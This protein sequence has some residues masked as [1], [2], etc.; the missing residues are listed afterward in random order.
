MKLLFCTKFP[1]NRRSRSRRRNTQRKTCEN[2][3]GKTIK[4]R[5]RDKK[6]AS[7]ND[8]HSVYCIVFHS[9]NFLCICMLLTR[10]SFRWSDGELIANISVY[11][12]D[13]L[14]EGCLKT[15]ILV[16]PSRVHVEQR[17]RSF[18]RLTS[19]G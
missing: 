7:L 1:R 18:K 13:L 19:S 5:K 12:S 14:L 2:I 10:V 16:L 3:Y 11:H 9:N 17:E 4:W 6:I 8:E 15:F